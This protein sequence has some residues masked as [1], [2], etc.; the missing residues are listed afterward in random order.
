MG[1]QYGSG[2][3]DVS[4]NLLFPLLFSS[5]FKFLIAVKQLINENVLLFGFKFYVRVE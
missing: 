4:G 3:F 2:L 5:S 1:L